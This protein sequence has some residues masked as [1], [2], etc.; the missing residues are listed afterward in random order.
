MTIA[1]RPDAAPRIRLLEREREHIAAP[2]LHAALDGGLSAA[3]DTS[4]DATALLRIALMEQLIGR[5]GVAHERIRRAEALGAPAAAVG[6]IRLLD[7]TWECVPASAIPVGTPRATVLELAAE[8]RARLCADR[9][10][11]GASW[12]EI[13]ALRSRVQERVA[14]WLG[15]ARD[16]TALVDGVGPAVYATLTL[17]AAEGADATLRLLAPL[18]RRVLRMRLHAWRP[19]IDY[20]EG[21]C[22]LHLGRYVEGE[23]LLAGA[24]RSFGGDPAQPLL[25]MAVAA[26]VGVAGLTRSVTW[27]DF[28]TLERRLIE[29]SWRDSRPYA[30]QLASALLARVAIALGDDARGLRLL[31]IVGTPERLAMTHGERVLAMDFALQAELRVSGPAAASR[32]VARVE[33]LFDSPTRDAALAR[34]RAR[35]GTASEPLSAAL[36][37]KSPTDLMRAGYAVVAT[38][39]RDAD[40]TRALAQLAELD[41]LS[42]RLRANAVRIRAARL[43]L[44]EDDG[45]ALSPRQLEVAALAA[46][47]LTNR[48]IAE[49][50]HVSP[51]TVESHVR[52]AL[53]L[54]GLERR[55]QLAGAILRADPGA[56]DD[57]RLSRRQG[58]VA[59]LV[60][61][62]CT[63]A[64]IATALS[65]SENTVEKHVSAAIDALGAGTR[66]GLAAAFFQSRF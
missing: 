46:G 30:R 44:A 15:E 52:Q 39:L 23:R 5:T 27:T 58:Q 56:I 60:A 10:V 59:A 34:M 21:V 62:G 12:S 61:V 9:G 8:L 20:V 43:F 51:R 24:I 66:A 47:G 14:A 25:L 33:E 1:P 53:A 48:Q 64:E 6:A 19:L 42:A 18:R 3:A 57:G 11:G 17:A 7:D 35:L 50:L 22:A 29:G 16:A 40:R 49:Q 37:T 2:T 4:D 32:W 41:Q 26:R 54:L 45:H 63:N 65:V 28:D 38:A 36:A 13:V 31:G 55:G